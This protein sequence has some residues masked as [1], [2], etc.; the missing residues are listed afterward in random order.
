MS[1]RDTWA[2]G[3]RREDVD[4]LPG[5]DFA[6]IVPCLDAGDFVERLLTDRGLS[7]VFGAPGAG[8][9][10]WAL[11]LALH[12]AWGEA[13]NGR[14]VRAGAVM[15]LCLEGGHG[16]RN[17]VAAWRQ[18]H[19]LEDSALPF[20][21]F[22][23]SVDLKNTGG[24]LERVL[25]AAREMVES[26]GLP[27]RL[28]VVDT[29]SHALAGGD[30][31]SSE[32]MG[33]L[34]AVADAIRQDAGA[35]LLFIHHPGNASSERPRGWSGLHAALDTEIRVTNE[36]GTRQAEVTKARDFPAGD[37]FPFRLDP[38]ELG[39]NQRGKP[40]TSCVAVALDAGEVP[41]KA[42]SG[43]LHGRSRQAFEVLVEI[44]G[45][46]GLAGFHGVPSG[47]LSVPA[48]RWREAFYSRAMVTETPTA[49]RKAF[50][51]AGATLEEKK[52]IAGS[53]GRVWIVH[54]GAGT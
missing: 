14:E 49:R 24:D 8:K 54:P 53:A 51:R 15:Y 29:L 39:A 4:V 41:R 17:R 1:P 33:A 37:V 27:V 38:V 40:V 22:E 52:L 47:F 21:L 10:F 11:D 35:H 50:Q 9:T 31:N 12:V 36:G 28:V 26:F 34:I 25:A 23:V 5:I 3:A 48:D 2:P 7:L 32:G 45:A 20:R 13:W 6:D 43:G 16:I 46:E 30:E 42:P 18:Q 44:L 19:G